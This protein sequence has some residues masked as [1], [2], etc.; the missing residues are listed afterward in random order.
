MAG[1]YNNTKCSYKGIKFDSQMEMDFYVKNEKYLTRLLPA[2]KLFKHTEMKTW[3]HTPD[4]QTPTCYI[5]TK[6]MVPPAYAK[7]IETLISEYGDEFRSKYKLVFLNPKTRIGKRNINAGQWASSLGLEW[8][9]I[10]SP[11]P[12]HWLKGSDTIPYTPTRLSLLML[13]AR[14]ETAEKVLLSLPKTGCVVTNLSGVLQDMKW[15]KKKKHNKELFRFHP[16]NHWNFRNRG[17]MTEGIKNSEIIL[18]IVD[19]TTNENDGY[20][21]GLGLRQPR[22]VLDFGGEYTPC[23]ST[24]ERMMIVVPV[25]KELQYPVAIESLIV[26]AMSLVKTQAQEMCRD[27]YSMFNIEEYLGYKNGRRDFSKLGKVP[28]YNATTLMCCLVSR[29]QA[30]AR[31]YDLTTIN[32]YERMVKRIPTYPFEALTG[33]S[34]IT[35]VTN[36]CESTVGM[37]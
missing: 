9:S 29:L 35:E 3:T 16:T 12:E 23:P 33:R 31:L 15:N 21:L 25:P 36:Y 30:G 5:E 2:K 6:G 37:L 22:I 27:T 17:K 10:D 18:S 26:T 19:G 24:L 20:L 8:I 28:T 32:G 4:F 7:R 13:N 34:R 1:K 14:M 11:V